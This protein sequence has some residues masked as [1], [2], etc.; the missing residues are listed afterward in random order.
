MLG[1]LNAYVDMWLLTTRLNASEKSTVSTF[2][3]TRD[4]SCSILPTLAFQS[5]LDVFESIDLHRRT[6]S[7]S[8]EYLACQADST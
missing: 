3:H 5:L 7:A 2:R 6:V 8:K 1:E 4:D